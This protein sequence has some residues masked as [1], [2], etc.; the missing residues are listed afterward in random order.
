M[1]PPDKLAPW[2]RRIFQSELSRRGIM[3]AFDI[4]TRNSTEAWTIDPTHSSVEFSVRHLMITTVRGR[5]GLAAGTVLTGADPA[6]REVAVEID[7]ASIDTG[8]EQRDAH[9]RSADFLDAGNHPKLVFRSDKVEGDFSVPG[10]RFQVIGDLT[11]RGVTRPATLDV[12]FEGEG[13]DPWGGERSSFTATTRIDRRDFGLTW[14]QGLE[15]GGVLVGNEV[16]IRLDVQ[17]I[18]QS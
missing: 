9:L 7:A 10:D 13:N 18:R 1:L 3:S 12:T 11:I 8:T 16:T 6:K 5:L 15:S 4:A 14:N 2:A 17:L